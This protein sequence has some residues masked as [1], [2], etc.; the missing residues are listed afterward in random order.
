MTMTMRSLASAAASGILALA[1]L[2]APAAMT[3]QGKATALQPAALQK[4]IPP[5]VFYRGQTTTTELRNSGG[6]KFGDGYYFLASLVDT[7]GYSNEVASKFQAY[8]ITE[9]PVRVGGV[10]LGAGVYGIGFLADNKFTVTDVGGHTVLTTDSATDSKL[11]RPR[12]LEVL[13]APGGG[14]RL[15]EGRKYV[16]LER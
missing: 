12:P 6:V 11:E 15:Y 1:I 16:A 9:V 2:A 10:K 4:L 5:R 14:F 3:A 8:F 7:S 13:A